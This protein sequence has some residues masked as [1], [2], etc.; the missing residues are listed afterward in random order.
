MTP[1]NNLIDNN[2]VIYTLCTATVCL[3]TGFFIK[4]YLYSTVIETPNSPPIF[5]LNIDHLEEIQ[6]TLD[7]GDELDQETPQNP[8]LDRDQDMLD[9]GDEEIQPIFNDDQ[10]KEILDKLNRGEELDQET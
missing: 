7:Q 5:Y 8:N 10:L 2:Y 6:E 9:Q 1:Y 3:I 4:S